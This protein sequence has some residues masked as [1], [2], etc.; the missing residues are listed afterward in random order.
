[1]Q[2]NVPERTDKSL[3][4]GGVIWFFVR[5]WGQC[6]VRCDENCSCHDS[7]SGAPLSKRAGRQAGH[8]GASCTALAGLGIRSQRQSALQWQRRQRSS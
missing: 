1:M 5:F 2:L 6:R 3:A 4:I 7:L 8:G